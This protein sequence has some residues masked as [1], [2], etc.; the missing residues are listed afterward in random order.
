MPPKELHIK[1]YKPRSNILDVEYK[2]NIYE[3]N[4]QI[5]NVS[6]L[7]LPILIRIIEASAP[8]G[9]DVVVENYD[10]SFGNLSS[11]LSSGK[12]Y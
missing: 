3:R 2:L 8:Q 9:V 12:N 11:L 10:R 7:S 6:S 1:R 4:I 5:S